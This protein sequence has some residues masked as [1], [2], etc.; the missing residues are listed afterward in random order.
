[1]PPSCLR[2]LHLNFNNFHFTIQPS[3]RGKETIKYCDG[4]ED[5]EDIQDSYIDQLDE[6]QQKRRKLNRGGQGQAQQAYEYTLPTLN[7]L[8]DTQEPD[9]ELGVKSLPTPKSASGASTTSDGFLH[10]LSA[11]ATA[12]L[13]GDSNDVNDNQRR[14]LPRRPR[15][16]SHLSILSSA[17]SDCTNSQSRGDL[18]AGKLFVD[19]KTSLQYY[20]DDDYYDNDGVKKKFQCAV[21]G[22]QYHA[23]VLGHLEVH[24]RTHTGKW[25]S[26]S[27]F[28]FFPT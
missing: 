14:G 22:C 24:N 26:E 6:R 25:W 1:M 17:L 16:D 11:V 28:S 21:E 3:Q 13:K 27:S 12:S 19:P 23:V 18:V 15:A 10:F 7:S 8:Q 9:E 5:D 2:R 20:F 4:Y